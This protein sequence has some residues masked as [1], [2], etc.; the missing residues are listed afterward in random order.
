MIA[1]ISNSSSSTVT[2]TARGGDGHQLSTTSNN[3]SHHHIDTMTSTR[4]EIELEKQYHSVDTAPEY[5]TG[6]FPPMAHICTRKMST[7]IQLKLAIEKDFL[8]VAANR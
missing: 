2:T 4:V 8:L 3:E 7:G 6:R 5:K 1:C